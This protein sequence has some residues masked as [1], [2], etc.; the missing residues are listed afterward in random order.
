M[1]RQ[2][3]LHPIGQQPRDLRL[4][5]EVRAQCEAQLRVLRAQV[6][7]LAAD[8][9]DQHA[10]EQVV[11][12]HHDL[13][14]PEQGLPLH[15]ALQTREGDAGEGEV[16][17]LMLA[18]LLQPARHLGHLAIG[19]PVGRAAPEQHHA[20][21]R[22]VGHVERVH[23]LAQLAL[24]DGEDGFAHAQV[25]RVVETHAGDM[26]ASACDVR[27]DF[28]LH[29][30]GGVEDQGHDDDALRTLRS[31]RQARLHLDIGEL[32]EAQFGAPVG[33]RVA[34]QGGKTL[35]L[36]VARLLARA[37]AHQQDGCGVHSVSLGADA[38]R[39]RCVKLAS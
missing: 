21:G 26:P 8:A 23:A 13:A 10:G 30:A 38:R 14:Q 24:Q 27:R 36:V 35:D 25:R 19:V 16:D 37:V 22:G 18:F 11:G 15:H 4:E 5:A 3:A 31:T 34:P 17:R 29:M 33:V 12:Q 1:A 32:D 28:H 2:Q 9:L 39:K 20:G 7:H 6:L